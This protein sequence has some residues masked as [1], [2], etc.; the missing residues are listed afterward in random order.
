M[1]WFNFFR[2]KAASAIDADA[3]FKFAVSCERKNKLCEAARF[4]KVAADLGN[5]LAQSSLA[6]FY[7]QGLGGLP[8]DDYEAAWLYMRA[9]GRG[10]PRAQY[11]L[12]EFYRDGRGGLPQN[13]HEAANLFRLAA[14]QGDPCAEC[15]LAFLYRDGLGGSEKTTRRLCGCSGPLLPRG[16]GLR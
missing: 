15:A 5:P 14:S 2:S 4:Y 9:A 11:G 13:D 1:A 10:I 7:E 12:G 16:M 8:R 6:Q 3:A